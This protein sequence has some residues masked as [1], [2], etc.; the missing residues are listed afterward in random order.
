METT[1]KNNFNDVKKIDE[2]IKTILIYLLIKIIIM[3]LFLI[4]VIM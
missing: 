2:P 4:K 3:N 1:C